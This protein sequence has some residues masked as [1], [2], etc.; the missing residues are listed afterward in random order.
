MSLFL[1]IDCGGTKTEVVICDKSG[2]EIATKIGP[3]SNIHNST[4]EKFKSNV[5]KVINAAFKAKE[6]DPKRPI[7]TACIGVA[8]F[9]SK[10]DRQL[11]QQL[12]SSVLTVNKLLLV[13]DGVIAFKSGS[14]ATDGIVIISSTGS[15]VYSLH[16]NEIKH[17]AGDWGYLLGD[18]GSAYAFGK[19]LL[20]A[21]VKEY[22]GRSQSTGLIDHV[23][24][25]FQI[26]SFANLQQMIYG[27]NSIKQI[28][29]LGELASDPVANKH[30]VIQQLAAKTVDEL[31]VSYKSV[32]AKANFPE[33]K[34]FPVILSG[35]FFQ[36]KDLIATPLINKIE[37]YT[38]QAE[39]TFPHQTPAQAAAKL[40]IA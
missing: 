19:N 23:F 24:N 15:G 2:K 20:Q 6:L 25:F 32:V 29:S 4:P 7:K 37:S 14:P 12:F 33:D 27:T 35:G 13:N 18:Q 21:A 40:A 28:A 11:L 39:T 26:N 8:G 1:G 10:E 3:G 9:D 38:P 34:P 22:D 5:A 16:Q 30:S 36:A 31:F 17:K